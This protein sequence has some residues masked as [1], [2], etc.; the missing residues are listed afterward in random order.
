MS[1]PVWGNLEKSQI[2][3][4]KIEEAIARLIQAHE[5]DPDA[6]VEVGESLQ[7]HKA[8]E[9]IDHLAKSII[10]DKILEGA[11]DLLKLTTTKSILICAFESLDGWDKDADGAGYVQATIF[12]LEMTSG[13]IQWEA[14]WMQVEPYGGINP[15]DFSKDTF[16]QTTFKALH[17]SNQ[18]IYFRA[19]LDQWF[20]FKIV[21]GTLYA[22]HK[23]TGESE[24][25]TQ[26]TGIT[27]TD[28]NIY[29]AFFDVSE[30][31]IYYYVNGALKAT[32]TTN[33]PSGTDAFMFHY[34]VMNTSTN[35]RTI[36]AR[37]LLWMRDR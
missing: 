36:F 6:H 22:C 10:G 3:P 15:I 8:A 32:H 25:T 19:G 16:F 34:F 20:G 29:R 7:S 26:I 33:L 31:K 13:A 28:F 35:V 4:E 23:K 18:E 14:A 37:D 21:G 2:D 5:D 17:N 1:L 27:I 11:V 9:I 24:V 12:G 30:A